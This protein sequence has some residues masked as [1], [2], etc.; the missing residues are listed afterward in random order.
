MLAWCLGRCEELKY[1][2]GS[3]EGSEFFLGREWMETCFESPCFSPSPTHTL[4]LSAIFI[5][6]PGIEMVSVFHCLLCVFL[7]CTN[8][9]EPS[10]HMSATIYS[11][12]LALNK[13][14]VIC[15]HHVWNPPHQRRNCKEVILCQIFVWKRGFFKFR[16]ATVFFF[17]A[18]LCICLTERQNKL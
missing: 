3:R 7:V 18:F 11:Y 6:T 9:W 4:S 12:A 17:R 16:F 5:D 2:L 15:H 10:I 8:L 14:W 13:V 1:L